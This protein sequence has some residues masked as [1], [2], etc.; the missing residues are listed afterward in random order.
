[1]NAKDVDGGIKENDELLLSYTKLAPEKVDIYDVIGGYD[2]ATGRNS[3]L[4]LMNEIFPRFRLVPGLLL[5][6]KFSA[7]PVV[8]AVMETMAENINGHFRCMTLCDIPTM[9]EGDDDELVP[10]RFTDVPAWK[11]QNNITST[12]QIS[13]TWIKSISAFS[14]SPL[15]KASY[16][17][18]Q[19][20]LHIVTVPLLCVIFNSSL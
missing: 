2:I 3:G 5:A 8:A 20:T 4:A 14:F 11:N 15:M 17:L 1:V 12:R 7:D 13:V 18:S 6:P 10:H 9:I 19:R 16:S